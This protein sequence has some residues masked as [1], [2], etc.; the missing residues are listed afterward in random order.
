M[1]IL[2]LQRLSGIS[3]SERYL[4][5]ILPKLK[6][7][8]LNVSFLAIQHP[9]NNHLNQSFL[10]QLEDNNIEIYKLNTY[11]P[12][13]L[14]LM[15]KTFRLIKNNNF[16]VLHT[17]LIHADFLGALVKKFLFP[18]LKILSVKHGY[19]EKFQAK[20]GFN[21][22]E[23]K[24]DLFFWCS[25]WAAKQADH[26]VCIS[27]SLEN[28]YKNSTMVEEHK[29]STIPYGFDFSEIPI[30]PDVKKYRFGTPQIVITGRV[31]MV[32]QHRLFLEILPILIKQFKELS[33]VMVGAGS[34]LEELKDLGKKLKIDNH[35]QWVGFQDNVHNFISNSDL[36]V[37][38]SRSEGFGLVILEAWHHSLPVIGFDVP[39]LNDI[40]SNQIDG[41][42]VRPFSASDLL[43]ETIDL[44][45]S[46]KKLKSLG[47]SGN[48]KL[49]KLYG[50]NTMVAS[51]INV[52]NELSQKID[53]NN[54]LI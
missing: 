24:P 2:F 21:I 44:L 5:S 37:I 9:K 1:K 26:V 3:G 51:T 50:I 27:Q 17:N 38:P 54:K 4:L 35:I 7:E 15:F 48:N 45:L 53:S 16:D 10:G 33:V 31:E 29:I 43:K 30:D 52:L 12:I 36:M 41:I 18:S 40:V 14:I 32:K 47:V 25:K 42:L 28:F 23:L 13:S 19:T 39:A 46:D 8:G 22:S 34:L 49:N 11:F 6:E 20:S